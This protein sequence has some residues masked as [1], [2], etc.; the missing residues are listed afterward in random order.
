MCTV[1]LLGGMYNKAY[2]DTKFLFLFKNLFC[3]LV[4]Y[5]KNYANVCVYIPPINCSTLWEILL[6]LIDVNCLHTK[7]VEAQGSYVRVNYMTERVPV[8][9]VALGPCV[10]Q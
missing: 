6:L 1:V 5:I 7:Q 4:S 2:P 9:A 8:L 10:C 3:F